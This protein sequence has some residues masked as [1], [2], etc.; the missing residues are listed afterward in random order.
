MIRSVKNIIFIV[1]LLIMPLQS[2]WA[3]A[4][5][6]CQPENEV[7]TSHFGHHDHQHEHQHAQAAGDADNAGDESANLNSPDCLDCHGAY[8]GIT[9][10]SFAAPPPGP[11]AEPPAAAASS[12]T[13]ASPSRPEKPQ[14]FSAV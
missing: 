10:S 5:A 4:A 12:L 14:W 8:N 9:V 13:S 6:Y 1:L 7:K 11:V 3:V 2:S